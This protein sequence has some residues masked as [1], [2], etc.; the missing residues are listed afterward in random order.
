[1]PLFCIFDK[2]FIFDTF[3]KF[4]YRLFQKLYLHFSSIFTFFKR[5]K[6]SRLLIKSIESLFP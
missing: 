4:Y 1:M 6:L 2:N 5:K 3:K